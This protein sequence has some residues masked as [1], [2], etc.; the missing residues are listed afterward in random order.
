LYTQPLHAFSLDTVVAS[1]G[2]MPSSTSKIITFFAMLFH[3][4]CILGSWIGESLH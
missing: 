3:S 4:Q 1:A 2:S